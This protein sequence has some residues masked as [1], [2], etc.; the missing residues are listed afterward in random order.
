[1]N[2]TEERQE[3]ARQLQKNGW[4]IVDLPAAPGPAT[5]VYYDRYGREYHDLPV[6]P[7]SVKHYRWKGFK[8]TPPVNPLPLP[9]EEQEVQPAVIFQPSE[10]DWYQKFRAG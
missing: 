8:L 2:R 1:M 9:V 3:I 6:D 10:D 4:A 5:G 7:Y